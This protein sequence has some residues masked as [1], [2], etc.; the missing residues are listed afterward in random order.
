MIPL[1]ALDL[2]LNSLYLVSLTIL[3]ALS[4]FLKSDSALY[5]APSVSLSAALSLCLLSL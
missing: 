5:L 2:A 3:L 1:A 4:I